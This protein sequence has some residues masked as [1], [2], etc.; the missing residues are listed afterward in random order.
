MLICSAALAQDKLYYRNGTTRSGILISVGNEQ[1]F[2]KMN[3]TSA[4]EQIKKSE[5]IMVQDVTGKRYIFSDRKQT[6]NSNVVSEK[7]NSLGMQPFGLLWGRA[8]IVYE[9]LNQKCNIG[10]VI[11]FSLTFDPFGSIYKNNIDSTANSIKRIP[12]IK[13]IAGI[14]LNFYI[15][16]N[17]FATFF[18]GPRF[19]YG[20]DLFLR[21]IEAYSY[22][23]QV[24]WR[25]GSPSAVFVQHI[26]AGAGFVNILS[27]PAGNLINPN[28]SYLWISI[29]YRAGIKW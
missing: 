19:R 16:E 21:N 4:A 20:T 18:I 15:G 5:L 25:F 7:R 6:K 8:T 28:Q 11:P 1:V 22:Q 3:D 9:R 13:F 12:G 2:F 24:G 26:S 10:L 17:K 29:N 23:T 27:S 14:D